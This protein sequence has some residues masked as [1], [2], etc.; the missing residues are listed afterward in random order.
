LLAL[1]L[2]G[3]GAI[4]VLAWDVAR[5]F[6]RPLAH[7][8]PLV[9]TVESGIAFSALA[10]ELRTQGV[11][12]E[13]RHV[14]YFT[15]YARLRGQAQK[16]QS[17]EY[18]I[19]P[20]LEPEGLLQ[21]LIS[22]RTRQYRLTVVE[23]WTFVELRRALEAHAAI[24]SRLAGADAAAV[25][26]AIGA[27]GEHPEGRFLPDTYHFPRDTTDVEFLRR[28]YRAMGQALETVWAGRRPDLP[29]ASPYQALILASI[30][31]K[32]TAM[33]E[34]RR[35]I[36]GVFVRRLQRGMLLQTDPTVIYGIQDFDGNIR[37]RD[38]HADTPY[39][40][41]TR[42]GLP[43]TPIALPGLASLRAVVDP[44]AGDA[45]YFVSRGDGSHVFSAT[46]DEHNRAVR[47]YQLGG[48]G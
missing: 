33:P 15:V 27:A 22:G 40:T 42:R 19:P 35:R 37:R 48:N 17:G 32:E 4:A 41:Y 47:K 38:L 28:A 26:T 39:N 24:D 9:F 16:V 30:V 36:A 10:D 25:M 11:F 34:E 23:G 8:E 20:A 43:P 18:E 29:L 7:T 13:P 45:L 14:D 46:L 6:E 2:A 1:L 31:E 44:A 5:F 3:I 21:L 12:A